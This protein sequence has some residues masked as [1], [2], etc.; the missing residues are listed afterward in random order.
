MWPFK[1]KNTPPA[2]DSARYQ[3]NPINLFFEDLILDILGRLPTERSTVIEKMNLQKVFSTEAVGWR[4]VIRE[5][6]RLSDT[7]DVAVRDLWIRNR[8]HYAQSVDGDRHFAQN[9][10]DM[11][12]ADDSKVDMW[13]EGALDAAKARIESFRENA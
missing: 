3:S 7:F 12:M 6:L 2:I 10:A 5:T 4:D 11:Y 13:P 8:S 1:K 9:F